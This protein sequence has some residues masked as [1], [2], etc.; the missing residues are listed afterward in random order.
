MSKQADNHRY[1]VEYQ[2]NYN[3]EYWHSESLYA[4]NEGKVIEK[5]TRFCRKHS[6]NVTSMRVTQAP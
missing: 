4:P 2:T 5:F 3:E 6:V 1:K